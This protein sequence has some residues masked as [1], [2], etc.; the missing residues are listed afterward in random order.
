MLRAFLHAVVLCA[1]AIS[2]AH[3]ADVGRVKTSSGPVHIERASERLPARVDTAVRAGDT[4]VTGAS[5]SVGIT[6]IDNSRISAGPGSTLVINRYA[7]D[8]TTHAGTFDTTLR[9]GTLAVASGRLAKQSPEAVT[10]RTPTM[11][12]GVRGTEF[13]VH[14]E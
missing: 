7:F 6:F 9:R 2:F 13:L 1:A 11:V 8:Q 5:G 10:V 3:A 14:A 12:L 4:V